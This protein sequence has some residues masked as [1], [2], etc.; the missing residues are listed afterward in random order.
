LLLGNQEDEISKLLSPSIYYGV[1]YAV[2]VVL[3]LIYAGLRALK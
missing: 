1:C 2:G 3:P